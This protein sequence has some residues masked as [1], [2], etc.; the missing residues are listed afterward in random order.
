M[1]DELSQNEEDRFLATDIEVSKLTLKDA[2]GRIRAVLQTDPQ[3]GGPNL[4]MFDETGSVR[5]FLGADSTNEGS[6]VCRVFTFDSGNQVTAQIAVSENVPPTWV[7]HVSLHSGHGNWA[8]Q[9]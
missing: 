2:Q 4:R 9:V 1:R 6:W 3:T 5:A 7:A 8:Q